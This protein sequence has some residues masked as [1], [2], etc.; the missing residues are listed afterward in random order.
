M[1]S[2]VPANMFSSLQ[3]QL[4]AGK[5]YQLLDDITGK[6]KWKVCI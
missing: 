5:E 4:E 6:K 2:C 1:F 3:L